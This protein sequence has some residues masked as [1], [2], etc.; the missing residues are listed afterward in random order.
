MRRAWYALRCSRA[1]SREHDQGS[2]GRF[3]CEAFASRV[4]MLLASD[5]G[6]RT[7]GLSALPV[8]TS[9]VVAIEGIEPSTEQL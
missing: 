3:G 9:Q 7:P 4:M 2:L 1:H 8:T 5:R 6:S